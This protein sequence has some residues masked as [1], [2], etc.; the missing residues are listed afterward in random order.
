MKKWIEAMRLRTL[1]VSLAGV[2]SG[3]A[4]EI[5]I[6]GFVNTYL[7]TDAAINFGN[8]GGPLINMAGQVVGMNAAKSITAGYDFKAN[9]EI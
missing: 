7:Q 8:S 5:N 9:K 3:T 4:R 2:I 1:P 6:D